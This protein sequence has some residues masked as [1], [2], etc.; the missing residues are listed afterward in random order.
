MGCNASSHKPRSIIKIHHLETLNVETPE[1]LAIRRSTFVFHKTTNVLLD[2][3]IGP[4]LGIG[5]FGSVRTAFHKATG[6]ERAIKTVKKEKVCKDMQ[7]RSKFFTE[8]DVLREINHPNILQLYE[9]YEDK[10][11]FHLVTEKLNGGELFEFIVSSEMLSESI[12]AHFI[13]QILNAVNYCHQRGIIHRDLKPE[14]LLLDKRSPNAILKVI[15]FGASGLINESEHLKARFG[16]SYYIAPEVLRRDYTEKCDIWSCGV[17]LYILLSG[18]PPFSGKTDDQIIKS[19]KKGVYSL[20]APEWDSISPEAKDLVSSL[21]QFDPSKRFSAEQ[22][23]NHPWFSHNPPKNF[24]QIPQN[25]LQSLKT[26]RANEKLQHAV[27]TFISSQLNSKEETQQLSENFKL[28]DK[29]GDGKLSKDELKEEFLKTMNEFEAEN[30]VERLL[31]LVDMD[32]N[33]FIDYS[34]FLTVCLKKETILNKRN[35]K[36]VFNM[37][38]I[39]HSGAISAEEI[40]RILGEEVLANDGIWAEIVKKV[41]QNGDGEIDLKEFKDMMMRVADE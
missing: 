11:S 32:Q 21:L 2:Y 20:S 1:K 12:A 37:F 23:L 36:F 29:N 28:I 3:S 17:I 41:D 18:K 14:N 5:A 13:Q 4:E 7:A 39:D 8:I 31:G 19:V 15:D 34:E 16:T 9:F 26:F 6:Q 25:I 10:K 33:G 24:H 30:E 35:L 27:L 40:K 22:A 38:D